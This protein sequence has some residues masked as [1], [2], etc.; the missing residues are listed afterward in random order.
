MVFAEL[1]SELAGEDGIAVEATGDFAVSCEVDLPSGRSLNAFV[2]VGRSDGKEA[3]LDI[4]VSVA[5][6]SG[7]VPHVVGNELLTKDFNEPIGAWWIIDTGNTRALVYGHRCLLSSLRVSVLCSILRTLASYVDTAPFV[8]A[9][10]DT[11]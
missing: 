5:R 11:E 9:L 4:F 2:G 7:P 3:V 10:G 8:A 1:V 6:Y